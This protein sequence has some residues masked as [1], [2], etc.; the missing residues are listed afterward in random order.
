MK[1]I[2]LVLA[3]ASFGASAVSPDL[4]E[5][6]QKKNVTLTE[7]EARVARIGYISEGRQ[8]SGGILG[9]YP[10]GLGM[11]HAI[12]GRWRDDGKF[13]TFSQLGA[14]TLVAASGDCVGKVMSNDDNQCGGPQEVLLLTGVIAYLGLRV[15]EI[16]DV[17]S[18]PGKQNRRYKHL[19][20][21][22]E[23]L[24]DAPPAEPSTS[25]HLVPIMG[26]LSSTGLGLLLKF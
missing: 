10:I 18:A 7:R 16:V 1:K 2:L 14:L 9:T 11:G 15:W 23:A 13:F 6:A 19:R 20:D 26:P 5:V 12:Q 4:V 17:W 25:L 21:R 3:L 8:L 24:P 22:L